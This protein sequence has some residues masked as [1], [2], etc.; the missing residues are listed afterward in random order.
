MN[1]IVVVLK[2]TK[3]GQYND[4]IKLLDY[5]F[6]N[7]VVHELVREGQVIA[8]TQVDN[9]DTDDIGT[10]N[11]DVREGVRDVFHKDDIG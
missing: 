4:S 11:I 9:H 5:G 3:D 2:S 7:F 8:T 6:N 10:L 1:L